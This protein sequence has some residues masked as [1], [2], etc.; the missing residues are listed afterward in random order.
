M[1]ARTSWLGDLLG[2]FFDIKSVLLK[3]RAHS[4]PAKLHELREARHV[5]VSSNIASFG[6]RP[7]CAKGCRCGPEA[8]PKAADC[9]CGLMGAAPKA[10]GLSWS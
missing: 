8:A 10:A 1:L 9:R 6:L 4:S 7:N 5:D 3:R 2:G